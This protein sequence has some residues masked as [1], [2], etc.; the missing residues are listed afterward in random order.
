MRESEIS[1]E[2]CQAVHRKAIIL[3]PPQMV[4]FNSGSNF[5]GFIIFIELVDKMFL[6]IEL[7][8]AI[9]RNQ[10]TSAQYID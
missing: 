2:D 8:I 3:L 7:F 5:N 1:L 9:S 10:F 4:D 6:V